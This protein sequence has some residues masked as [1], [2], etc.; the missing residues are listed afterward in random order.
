[1]LPDWEIAVRLVL[2]AAL[3]SFIG[4]ERE[5]LLW[6][7]GIRTHMV[8]CVGACLVMVVSAY[9]FQGVLNEHVILDPSRVAAQVVSGI[10]FLGAGSILLRGSVVRG[11]TTAAS[12]WT[13]AAIGLAIGGGLYF[14]GI[15]ST[16]IIL[17]ILAGVKPLEEAYRARNQSFQ[18]HIRAE[19]GKL[20]PDVLK[21]TLGIRRGQVK[22][23]I[24]Q[25]SSK[26]NDEEAVQALISQISSEQAAGFGRKLA[27]LAFVRDVKAQGRARKF[28]RRLGARPAKAH[29]SSSALRLRGDMFASV[30]VASSAKPISVSPSASGA[31][32]PKYR[33]NHNSRPTRWNSR[34]PSPRASSAISSVF[35]AGHC[36]NS[37]SMPPVSSRSVPSA[38]AVGNGKPFLRAKT[39]SWGSTSVA[40]CL[41]SHLPVLRCS[42]ARLGRCKPKSIRSFS[43][44]GTRISIEAAMPIRSWRCRIHDK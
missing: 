12:I 20:T 39:T 10:G 5:R 29:R 3:G 36:M 1:M 38:Y 23:F 43:R 33:R 11:L 8:V 6:A 14:A 7:A 2:A 13:V 31:S 34:P 30:R 27:S 15:A 19:R 25:G 22:R 40:A 4:F 26:K 17:I 35:T 37:A 41:T 28:A 44:N 9:G 21:S 42:L 24:T 16:A 32:P 18:F